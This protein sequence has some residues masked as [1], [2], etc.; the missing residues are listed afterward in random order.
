SLPNETR[1]KLSTRWEAYSSLREETKQQVRDAAKKVS[2]Q[3]DQ[4]ILL[5][6]L[7]AAAVWMQG[8]SD[9]LR[10]QIQSDDSEVSEKAI[11]AAIELTMAELES[12]SGKMISDETAYQIYLWVESLLDERMASA[13]DDRLVWFFRLDDRS[14]EMVKHGLMVRMI[15][16]RTV[17]QWLN[18]RMPFQKGTRNP[19]GGPPRGGFPDGPRRDERGPD[20]ERQERGGPERFG[21]ER[22]GERGGPDGGVGRG[23]GRGRDQGRSLMESPVP[24]ITNEELA[25]LRELL[26]ESALEDLQHVTSLFRRVGGESAANETLRSWASEAVKRNAPWYRDELIERY[27]EIE[28]R[29]AFDLSPPELITQELY[30]PSEVLDSGSSE[31][32]EE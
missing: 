12:D 20:R 18:A 15:D 27:R 29:D 19:F 9:E 8:L 31:Q 28:K 14:R 11:D 22:G 21:A 25:Q 1:Q 7:K 10:D 23:R 24:R 6:T 2:E 26:S 4:A 32:T 5:Q 3:A 17:R 13:Q 16:D 30:A